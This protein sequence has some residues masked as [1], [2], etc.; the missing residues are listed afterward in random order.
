MK[1]ISNEKIFVTVV[2]SGSFKG[3]A[4]SLEMDP[5]LVSR[6]VAN[7]EKRLSVKLMERSTKQSLPT[8]QGHNYYQGLKRLL[9][10]QQA[11]E[12]LVADTVNVPTGHLKVTAPHD[13]GVEFVAETL[14]SMTQKKVV[15]EI[16]KKEDFIKVRMEERVG[17]IHFLSMKAQ[18]ARI[19]LWIVTIH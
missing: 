16:R 8:E 18:V 4:E 1:D 15:M 12:S 10:E 19:S 11:L 14:E 3:A 13:F 5:S 2:E 17:R 9:E 7:L 6:R